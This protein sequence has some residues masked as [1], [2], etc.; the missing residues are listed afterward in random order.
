M[1]LTDDVPLKYTVTKR[2]IYTTVAKGKV[3]LMDDD[4][5]DDDTD[6]DDIGHSPHPS[7]LVPILG[8]F[9]RVL[10]RF[11]ASS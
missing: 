8:G 7:L 6:D 3:T 11:R 4:D 1:G 10:P 9:C 5:D 2:E